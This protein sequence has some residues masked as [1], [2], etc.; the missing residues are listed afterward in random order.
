MPLYKN[1]ETGETR[2]YARTRTYVY[3]DGSKKEVDLSSGQE[4]TK[5]WELVVEST[6]YKSVI[7]KKSPT[8]GFGTR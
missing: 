5:D 3:D 7:A 4:I 2:V 1:K 8:D 6:D